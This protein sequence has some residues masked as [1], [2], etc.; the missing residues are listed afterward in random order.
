MFA[1]IDGKKIEFSS[2]DTILSVATANGINIP[3]L[4]YDKRFPHY[5]ACFICVVKDLK[6]G[7][8]LPSCSSL[9]SDGMEISSSSDEVKKYRKLALELL[10]SEH[11]ADCFSPCKT[12]CP[13]GIDARDY[14]LF[15]KNNDDVDGFLKVRE[16]NPLV[17]VVGRVCPAFC[18]KDC[19]RNEIDEAVG[20]RLIKRSLGDAIY[21]KR[22]AELFEKEKGLIKKASASK[23][24][25][26]IGGGPAGL[27]CAYYLCLNGHKPVIYDENKELGGMLR[28]SIPE[29]RLPRKALDK[30]I[31][32]IM[33]LGVEA[34]MQVRVDK[35]KLEELKN[36]YDA[37]VV[38]VGTW[39]ESAIGLDEQKF[40]NVH[41][42][43]SF[44]K[45]VSLGE[46]IVPGK[47]AVVIGGGNSAVDSAR[48]LL[49]LGFND[50]GLY[51]R[52]TRE[53]MPA[54]H[55]EIE[56][57]LHE[58][59]RLYELVA[60]VELKDKKIS[61]NVME[62]SCEL[63][64]SGR[65]KV[66]ETGKKI[67]KD[68]EILV[69]AI[70][71][72]AETDILSVEGIIP[73]GDAKNGATTVIEAVADG[74]RVAYGL[75]K[76]FNDEL[77]FYSQREKG[78]LSKT[79]PSYEKTDRNKAVTRDVSNRIKDFGEAE[80]GF[81]PS[82]CVKEAERCINCG[83][84]AI[85]D[86]SLRDLSVEY[87]ADP[88]RYKADLSTGGEKAFVDDTTKLLIHEPSK[89]IKCGTCV[90]VCKNIA[91]VT[92]LSFIGRGFNSKIA[93]GPTAS[94]NESTCILCGMCIDS[95]PTGALLE[96]TD[97]V[98]RSGV[99]EE[100][101]EC[102]GCILKCKI[103]YG[104][105]NG[106]V[107]RARSYDTPICSVG[108]WG[109]VDGYKRAANYYSGNVSD[110]RIDLHSLNVQSSEV[111]K[112]ADLVVCL[113]YDP[114]KDNP[115]VAYELKIIKDSGISVML[116]QDLTGV[117][118]SKASYPVVIFSYFTVPRLDELRRFSAVI[119]VYYQRS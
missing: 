29:Y 67:E 3:T 106:K 58:G 44:L 42:A 65:K 73:C 57:A 81:T 78:A 119:P 104:F 39:K 21:D 118:L 93:A 100:V 2:I 51:Y 77:S 43:L 35:T 66:C 95:C 12:S 86:C 85:E 6:T 84:G 114:S 80:L 109:W 30:E 22:D 89:C 27:S 63:D 116:V 94:I 102:E 16:K 111:L 28:Y 32:S 64:S 101:K 99:K 76:T 103:R 17:G 74:R 92:A 5:T 26:I 112:K 105:S 18:E 40:N 68:F 31:N 34:K 82:G 14:I 19:S 1:V 25:A 59:V 10:L 41:S 46:K 88:V 115:R 20:I 108:R 75:E 47:R 69:Y 13:A 24:I 98:I 97:A 37:V 36:I 110:K 107:F 87:G 50:V 49:R 7:K 15:A 96:N 60:P 55:V 4:C 83:C 90:R 91:G 23:K 9:I 70:G 11:D 62:L 52:R 48:T 56:E 117:D 79:L 54:D 53:Q 72:K 61:F 8:L 45:R 38:C 71:Q 113:T 33:R